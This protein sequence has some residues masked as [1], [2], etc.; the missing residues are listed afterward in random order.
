MTLLSRGP[1]AAQ[2][3]PHARRS[4]RRAL[5]RL[6]VHLVEDATADR[7]TDCAVILSDGRTVEFHT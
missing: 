4:I 2:M 3:R 6:G 7:I 5:T 1:V